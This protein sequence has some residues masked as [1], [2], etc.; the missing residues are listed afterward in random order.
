M[1]GQRNFE[2]ENPQRGAAIHYYLKSGGGDVK[3][4]ISD[5]NGKPI[6]TLTATAKP[7]I[8]RVMWNLNPDPPQG[9]GGGGFGGGGGGRGGGGGGVEPGTYLVT[10][11]VG[12]KTISKP[13]TVL[14]DRW[15]NER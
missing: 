5:F 10:L 7:G 1:T 4:S 6:R 9:G 3:L 12:G 11:S 8:N 2:G 13:V 14:Q 15:L